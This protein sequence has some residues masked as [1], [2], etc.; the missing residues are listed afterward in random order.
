[1]MTNFNEGSFKFNKGDKGQILILV[2]SSMSFKVTQKTSFGNV[3]ILSVRF[4]RVYYVINDLN[5]LNPR[6]PGK[7]KQN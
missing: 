4:R 3:K 1:M 7:T 5:T 2:E 6:V